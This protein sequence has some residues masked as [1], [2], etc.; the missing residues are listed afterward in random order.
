MGRL[1]PKIDIGAFEAQIGA[2]VAFQVDAPPSVT[3]GSP[4]DVTFTAL[5]NYGHVAAA[6]T[7]TVTFSTSDTDPGV[8]LPGDY[9]FT[10][11]DQG[12][13]TFAGAFTLITPGEQ[14]LTATDTADGSVA[15]TTTVTVDPGP[16]APAPGGSPRPVVLGR[17]LNNPP[18]W[19]VQ[20]ESGV[21]AVDQFFASL[22]GEESWRF[23]PR[24]HDAPPGEAASW[25]LD[26]FRAEE[27]LLI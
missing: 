3:A 22:D 20:P 11:D 27:G 23:W 14:T 8:V 15:G 17:N 18:T 19:A 21:D 9:N 1:R 5:D 16:P 12:V 6:Y 7:G 26:P 4:F 25:R 24:W 13:H 10:A 2:A